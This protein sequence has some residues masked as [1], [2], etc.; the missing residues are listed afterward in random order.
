M[1]ED[2]IY[3]EQWREWINKCR[4]L[5]GTVDMSDLI[6]VRSEYAVQERR[7]KTGDPDYQPPHPVLFGLKE[8]R[9]AKA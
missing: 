9:I 4:M 1:A 6:Y 2:P 5:L 8:G 3:D 7:R